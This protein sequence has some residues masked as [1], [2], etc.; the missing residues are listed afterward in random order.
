[1]EKWIVLASLI[2]TTACSHTPSYSVIGSWIQ[3]IPGQNRYQG[4][5]LEPDGTAY[6]LGMRTLLYTSW[7][8]KGDLLIL[9]GSS[10]GNGGTFPFTSFYRI[11]ELTEN[12]LVLKHKSSLLSYERMK[13]GSDFLSQDFSSER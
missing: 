6:S 9:N 12:K 8:Q 10:I 3:P 4:I 11:I 1:M 2:L 5:Q 13:N 7:D